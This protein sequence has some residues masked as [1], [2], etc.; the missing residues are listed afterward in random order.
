G[1]RGGRKVGGGGAGAVGGHEVG[2]ELAARVVER[3]RTGDRLGEQ[4]L[5]RTGNPLEEDVALC[6]KCD[7]AKA[8]RAVLADDRLRQLVA[9]PSVEVSRGGRGGVRQRPGPANFLGR[10][11]AIAWSRLAAVRR[12]R[13]V[14]EEVYSEVA[15]WA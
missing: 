8:D 2:G 12:S 11:W 15:I 1:E 13:S 9:K 3:Q 10:G 14:D 7:R 4:R 6:Y 5:A